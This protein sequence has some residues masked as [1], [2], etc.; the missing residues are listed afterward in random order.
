MSAKRVL[1]VDDNPVNLKLM[2]FVLESK[3]FQ[4]ETAHDAD[5]ARARLCERVPALVLM[6]VQ[7]P[8]TDGLTLTRALRDDRRLA[9]VPI[10]AVTAYAMARDEQA[11]L[12]A[13]CD[14]F[15]TKPLDTRALGALALRLTTERP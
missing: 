6:D 9:G 3:G 10:I 13:G 11:A 1:I 8:G 4:V 5:S 14:A 2:R 12:D 7:L 15:L